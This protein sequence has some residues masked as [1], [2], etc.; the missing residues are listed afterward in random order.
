[1]RKSNQLNPVKDYSVTEADIAR[2]HP[3]GEVVSAR[4]YNVNKRKACYIEQD[5]GPGRV[6]IPGAFR[7][8]WRKGNCFIIVLT[9]GE[10]DRSTKLFLATVVVTI[11]V[12]VSERWE[13]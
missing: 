5:L 4:E 13:C 10:C 12:V 1:M 7:N 6:S 9:R 11:S 3:E 8:A 2:C